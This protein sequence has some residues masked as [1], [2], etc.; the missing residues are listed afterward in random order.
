M[1]DPR[2]VSITLS[3]ADLAT[4]R[5]W[6]RRRSTAQG[7]AL[8]ARIVLACAGPG[9]TNLA[10][11]ARLGISNLTVS[12]W[13]RRFAEQGIEGLSDAPRPGVPRRILDEQIERVIT[14]TLESTQRSA[15]HWSTRLPTSNTADPGLMAGAAPLRAA[16]HDRN[17]SPWAAHPSEAHRRDPPYIGLVSRYPAPHSFFMLAQK[18]SNLRSAASNTISALIRT[19]AVSQG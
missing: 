13:R 19:R 14:T 18:R 3:D 9:T 12:K 11:A 4:Q 6:T 17:V 15:T 10:V 5:S 8:R 7:L 1:A 2:A 16:V